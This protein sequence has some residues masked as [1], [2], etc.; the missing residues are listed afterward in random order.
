MLHDDILRELIPA[1][2]IGHERRAEL[3]YLLDEADSSPE[4]KARL[5][6]APEVKARLDAK[7]KEK[8]DAK[9]DADSRAK[10]G[11]GGKANA[12]A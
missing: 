12:P 9:A 8:A 2:A 6:A 10:S 5:E 3:L 1:A 11:A 7:A 4:A